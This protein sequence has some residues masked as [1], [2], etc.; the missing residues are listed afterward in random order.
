MVVQLDGKK[1]FDHVYHRAAFNET[2]RCE[3]VLDG[4][5]C[6]NREWKLYESALVDALVEVMLDLGQFDLGQSGFFR[7]R[8]MVELGNSSKASSSKASFC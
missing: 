4:I 1:A 5:G 6:C 2:A 3:S 8:P 7:L